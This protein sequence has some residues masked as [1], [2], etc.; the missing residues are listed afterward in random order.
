MTIEFSRLFS[1]L[2]PNGNRSAVSFDILGMVAGTAVMGKATENL[3]DSLATFTADLSQ[4]QIG[5][6]SAANDPHTRQM[7]C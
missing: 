5:N 2:I 7:R 6:F 3:G 1:S 4:A